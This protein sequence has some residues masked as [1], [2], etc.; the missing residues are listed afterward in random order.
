[1]RKVIRWLLAH[2]TLRCYWR[3]TYKDGSRTFPLSYPEAKGCADVFN[4][5]LWIDYTLKN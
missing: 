4:G 1:M 3:V 5:K 2:T